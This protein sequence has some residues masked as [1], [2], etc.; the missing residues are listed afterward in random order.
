MIQY[1]FGE[2]VDK[3]TIIHLKIWHIEED[4]AKSKFVN[5]SDIIIEKMC[6]QVINLNTTRNEIV[7]SLNELFEARNV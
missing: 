6:D 2:L 4:I 1:S 3:L 7:K 5:T